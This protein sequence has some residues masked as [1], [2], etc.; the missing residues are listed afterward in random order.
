MDILAD[1]EVVLSELGEA[2]NDIAGC[3]DG[4][5]DRSK[6][7]PFGLLVLANDKLSELTPIYFRHGKANNY[8]CTD[9]T[10]F[11]SLVYNG[12]NVSIFLDIRIIETQI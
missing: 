4:A 3:G 11:V 2:G 7:G 8:F 5:V 9:E 12:N 1:F 6:F 10:R